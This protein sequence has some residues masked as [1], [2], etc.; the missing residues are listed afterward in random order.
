MQNLKIFQS[1]WAMEQRIPGVPER[2]HEESF[3]IIAEAGY[4]GVCID[5]SVDEIAQSRKL[6]VHY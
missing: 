4:A 2:T 3:R 6:K 1:L 5:P